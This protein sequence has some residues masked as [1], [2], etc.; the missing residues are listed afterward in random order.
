MKTVRC[1]F[2]VVLIGG[3]VGCGFMDSQLSKDPVTGE[4]KL[5]AEVKAVAPVAGPYGTLALSV[6]T[7]LTGIYGAFHAR[8]ANKQTDQPAAKPTA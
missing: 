6:A 5:E 2:L 1:A 8:E 4:S 3:L 7:I